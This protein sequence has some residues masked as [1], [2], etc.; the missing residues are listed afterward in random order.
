MY[1][2]EKKKQDVSEVVFH[3]THNQTR[4]CAVFP[5]TLSKNTNSKQPGAVLFIPAVLLAQPH[6]IIP[7]SEATKWFM[8]HLFVFFL[9]L[10]ANAD[11]QLAATH[12]KQEISRLCKC[13]HH[14]P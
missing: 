6:R 1:G 14:K 9:R 12:G 13:F 4:S 8:S 11:P 10:R 7:E 3:Q 5:M 2:K